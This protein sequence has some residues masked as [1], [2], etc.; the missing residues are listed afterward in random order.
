MPRQIGMKEIEA[1]AATISSEG[2]AKY[3]QEMNDKEQQTLRSLINT[4]DRP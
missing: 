1:I 2:I 4:L 3:V